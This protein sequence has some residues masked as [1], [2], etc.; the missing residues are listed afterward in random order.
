MDYMQGEDILF[1]I[2]TVDGWLPVACLTDN[3]FTRT[4]ER[5][6]TTA[7]GS[8]GTRSYLPSTHDY[9]LSLSGILTKKAGVVSYNDLDQLQDDRIIFQWR[10][11]S[12]DGYIAKTGSSFITSLTLNSAARAYVTFSCELSPALG[13]LG[14][15]LVWSQ[16]GFNIVSQDGNNAIQI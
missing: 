13:E 7:R 12:G 16:D 9:N 8:G 1:Y 15:I 5:I 3:P 10:M 11:L 2:L 14:N 4:T 6:Q